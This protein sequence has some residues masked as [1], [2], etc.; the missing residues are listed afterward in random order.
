MSFLTSREKFAPQ[1]IGKSVPRREDARLLSGEG[2]YAND[3]SLPGQAYAYIVRA[4]HAHAKIAAIHVMEALAA[5]GVLAAQTVSV[6]LPRSNSKSS[7]AVGRC[8]MPFL[9]QTEQLHCDSNSRATR[10]RK[11][12]RPQWQP[13]SGCSSIA[14]IPEK[15]AAPT[16][17][18]AK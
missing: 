13:L 4:P 7:G 5:P 6:R 8:R 17:S 15:L 11:R 12:T 14:P 18:A 2:R 10:A 16:I 9:V 1:G 3:F